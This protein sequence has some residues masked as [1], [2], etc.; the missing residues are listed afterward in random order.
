MAYANRFWKSIPNSQALSYIAP[1]V[2]YSAIATY[3]LF[4]TTSADGEMG[5]FNA[6]TGA[7]ITAALA[8]GV[9]YF[10]AI[11]RGGVIE[12]SPTFT[13][14]VTTKV[15]SPYV[16]P[17]KPVWVAAT[18]GTIT[19]GKVWEIVIIDQTTAFI[20]Y[21]MQRY[22]YVLKTGDTLATAAAALVANINNENYPSNKNGQKLVTA[23]VV[24]TDDIQVTAD[25]F[26]SN[27]KV[28]TGEELSNQSTVTNTVKMVLGSGT[29]S[30]ALMF[31]KSGDIMKGVT[32]MHTNHPT[33]QP[34]D[35][36]IPP[37]KVNMSGTYVTYTFQTENTEDSPTPVEKHF[38]KVTVNLFA[39]DGA[40]D[41]LTELD[42][43]LT[44]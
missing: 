15:K 17:V 39:E 34:A 5:V 18:S 20:P 44:L 12:R 27:I 16:A 23:A 40:A 7:L 1:A 14:G 30:Q 3:K 42:L 2:E 9:K 8:A 38:R 6:D 33:A 32:H 4:V 35:F 21:P 22:Q 41:V 43:I 31:E 19:A 13:N 36:A 28:M 11:N 29:P 26:G 24:S 25:F 37:S 10:F